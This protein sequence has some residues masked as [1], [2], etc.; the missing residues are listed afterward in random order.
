MNEVLLN[1]RIS[2]NDEKLILINLVGIFEALK[3]KRLS[4]REA[5]KIF[6][7]PRM[8]NRL[9]FLKCNEKIV[10]ILERGCELE[11]IASLLP[12]KLIKVIEELEENSFD[13]MKQYPVFDHMF[14]IEL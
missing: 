14:W 6:F 4:I 13:I 8:V 5:E 9:K 3:K 12:D 1:N 10:D 7:S 2:E 11:D